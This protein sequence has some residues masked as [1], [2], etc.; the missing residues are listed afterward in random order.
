MLRTNLVS[1][2]LLTVLCTLAHADPIIYSGALT[3]TDDTLIGT[4]GWSESS[5][6]FHWDVTQNEDL[7][8]HYEYVFDRGDAQGNLSHLILQTSE[9]FTA[10]DI[11]NINP[12]IQSADPTW[13]TPGTSN[14]NMP[15]SIYGLKFQPFPE[16]TIS[17]ISFD[18]SRAPMWGDFYAKD[19][20]HGGQIWNAGFGSSEGA[21]IL[22]PDTQT[23]TI[24][25]PG[26]LL[27]SSL[28][29]GLISWLRRRRMF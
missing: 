25:A 20:A 24:P 21:H 10:A 15:S 17:T 4:G 8:W 11:W 9:N 14:P 7:S 12:A 13:Y 19:G 16:S 28:G 27:L 5:V 6:A 23:S 1:L 26:A 3:S 18:S 29:A 2:S 22:V